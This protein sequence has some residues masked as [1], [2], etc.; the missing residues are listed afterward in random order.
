MPR[1]PAIRRS[2]LCAALRSAQDSGL[3]VRSTRIF[4]DGGFSLEFADGTERQFG[5]DRID[6]ELARLEARFGEG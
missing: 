3:R 2:D 6:D 5:D 1:R 4:P